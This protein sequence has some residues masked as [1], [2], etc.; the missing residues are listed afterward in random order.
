MHAPDGP[1]P[2]G[3]GLGP[4]ALAALREA[5]ALVHAAPALRVRLR[6][7]DRVLATVAAPSPLDA[8]PP[9]WLT[10][11][12]FRSAVGDAWALVRAGR[13][14]G[15]T[16]CLGPEPAIDVGVPGGG[17]TH[18]LGVHRWPDAD[19]GGWRWAVATTGGV[20]TCR[21][22]CAALADDARTALVRDVRLRADPLL[23]CCVLLATGVAEAGDAD[24]VAELLG[25][26]IL[27]HAVDQLLVDVAS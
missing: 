18:P 5:A 26:V 20:A 7:G 3:D 17:A 19:G 24:G 12:A 9:R 8:P 22:A 13:P 4:A 25:D 15:L 1:L 14:V 6:D 21:A 27:R 10:P 23:G 16:G 2:V 11:C